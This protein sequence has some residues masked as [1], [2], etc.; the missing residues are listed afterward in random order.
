MSPSPYKC[1]YQILTRLA[2]VRYQE[3]VKN[4]QW[5]TL[6][7]KQTNED[8]QVSGQC[9][10]NNLCHSGN[11]NVSVM[12]TVFY[13]LPVVGYQEGLNGE[14]IETGSNFQ[15]LLST[16]RIQLVVCH[17]SNVSVFL[18]C[19]WS[20]ELSNLCCSTP[21]LDLKEKFKLKLEARLY[22]HFS[23]K[24][25]HEGYSIMHFACRYFLINKTL[26]TQKALI[27]DT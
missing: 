18:P 25:K 9:D 4:C 12:R 14:H 19:L 11:L 27:T 17:H 2:K 5:W 1:S 22:I 21:L 15:W 20:M 16:G 23:V 8:R 24:K 13:S 7:I 6:N 10:N 3:V 26:M